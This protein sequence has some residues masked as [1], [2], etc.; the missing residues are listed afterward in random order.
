[1]HAL[2]GREVIVLISEYDT[3]SSRATRNSM[4]ILLRYVST[5]RLSTSQV[6]NLVNILQAF[7]Q[8]L[9]TRTACV[10]TEAEVETQLQYD[11]DYTKNQ[12]KN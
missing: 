1:M 4:T 3:P 5:V 10:F 2:H 6:W 9:W 12:I 11:S 7:C 8:M